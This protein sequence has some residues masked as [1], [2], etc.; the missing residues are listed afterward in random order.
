MNPKFI[1]LGVSGALIYLAAAGHV[2][3]PALQTA[4]IAVGAVTAVKHVPVVGPVLTGSAAA[5]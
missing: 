4:M 5:A 2:K 1:A 3:N